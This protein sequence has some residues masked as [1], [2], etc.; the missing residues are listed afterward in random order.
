MKTGFPNNPTRDIVTEIEWIGRNGFDFVDLFLEFPHV[1]GNINVVKIRKILSAHGLGAVGHL[2]WYLP[3]G[4]P[5]KAIRET[6]VNEAESY[7]IVFE[8]L[9]VKLV[10]IHA[11]W[12]N[13]FSDKEC[14]RFQSSTLRNLVRTAREYDIRLMYELVDTPKDTLENV[15]SVLDAVP[16]LLFH[17]DIGHANLYGKKPEDFIRA[18]HKRLAHIHLHDNNGKFD[19]HLP[20]GEGNVK[21]PSVIKTLKENYDGTI[22]LE[23]FSPQKS[24]VL[25]S[26]KRLLELWKRQ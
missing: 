23:I 9:G 12:E 17:L 3:I 5:E 20:M 15:T 11:N 25:D 13:G 1:P 14:I 18:L 16:G 26:R 8:K 6:A 19:Q 22:T 21:W 2:A 7:F 4:S 24:L 10:K